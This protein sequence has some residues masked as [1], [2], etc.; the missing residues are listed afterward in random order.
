[1][2]VHTAL[3]PRSKRSK[4][5]SKRWADYAPPS[6]ATF[7]AVSLAASQVA[8]LA[9]L[10][11]HISP[12][13][14]KEQ[15][16]N[17]YTADA[18]AVEGIRRTIANLRTLSHD[19]VNDFLL[20]QRELFEIL[21]FIDNHDDDVSEELATGDVALPAGDATTC[22]PTRANDAEDLGGVRR[23]QRR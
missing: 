20:D 10:L 11:T 7:A 16:T 6:R 18:K 23:L 8:P 9:A 21:E 4:K 3:A 1:M 14:A 22:R 2:G 12:Q 15:K 13:P 19:E 5:R 17:E